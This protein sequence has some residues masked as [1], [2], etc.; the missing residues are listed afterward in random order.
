MTL[1][2][3]PEKLRFKTNSLE[4]RLVIPCGT[5][6][7]VPSSPETLSAASTVEIPLSCDEARELLTSLHRA[8]KENRKQVQDEE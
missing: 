4:L 8:L 3:K 7:L 6:L 2:A 1:K 5:T